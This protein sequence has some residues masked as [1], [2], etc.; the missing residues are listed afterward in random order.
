MAK[1]YPLIDRPIVTSQRNL[2]C[3]LTENGKK[4]KKVNRKIC[5]DQCK[6][7]NCAYPHVEQELLK[8]KKFPYRL[9]YHFPNCKRKECKFVHWDGK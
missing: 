6:T 5:E 1:L 2:C 3:F 4:K 8:D 9:C 7:D